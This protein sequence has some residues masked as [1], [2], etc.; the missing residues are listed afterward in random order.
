MVMRS[1][2]R[3]IECKK[4]KRRWSVLPVELTGVEIEEDVGMRMGMGMGRG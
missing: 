3:R 1:M 4:I 2:L